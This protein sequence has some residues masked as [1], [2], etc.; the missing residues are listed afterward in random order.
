MTTSYKQLSNLIRNRIEFDRFKDRL[1]EKICRNPVDEL[2]I[3][4]FVLSVAE[5]EFRLKTFLIHNYKNKQH[6]DNA[7][8]GVVINEF[9]KVIK[10]FDKNKLK[11]YRA[12]QLFESQYYNSFL[13]CCRAVN[14]LRNDLY[15]N[16][17]KEKQGGGKSLR[18]IIKKIKQR[19]ENFKT[20]YI[21]DPDFYNDDLLYKFQHRYR[22]IIDK[23]QI[24]LQWTL[25]LLAEISKIYLGILMNIKIFI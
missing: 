8:L 21:Y 4:L 2:Y 6:Y 17:F 5:I 22:S 24:P 16:L 19:T 25:E 11:D 15:H 23:D 10:S 9:T 18:N 14:T 13:V 7:T 12:K 20:S 3:S 1:K